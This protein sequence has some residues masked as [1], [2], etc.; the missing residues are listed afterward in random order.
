MPTRPHSCVTAKH[1]TWNPSLFNN[2]GTFHVIQRSAYSTVTRIIWTTSYYQSE[3]NKSSMVGIEQGHTVYY[4]I[5]VIHL[6]TTQ[7]YGNTVKIY[8]TFNIEL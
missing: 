1:Q 4:Y 3:V 7:M 6:F 5:L 8:F 2:L